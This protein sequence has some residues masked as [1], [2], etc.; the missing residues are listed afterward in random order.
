M[1]VGASKEGLGERLRRQMGT[2]CTVLLQLPFEKNC[3]QDGLCEGDLGVTLSF[4]G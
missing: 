1:L 2:E 4:S 3:G